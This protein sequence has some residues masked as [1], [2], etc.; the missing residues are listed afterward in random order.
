MNTQGQQKSVGMCA[1]PAPDH[2]AQVK[3]EDQLHSSFHMEKPAGDSQQADLLQVMQDVTGRVIANSALHLRKRAAELCLEEL[4]EYKRSKALNILTAPTERPGSDAPPSSS[5][6]ISAVPCGHVTDGSSALASK[7]GPLA[8]NHTATHKVAQCEAAAPK[9]H[10]N[11]TAQKL[12]QLASVQDADSASIHKQSSMQ[13]TA[14]RHRDMNGAELSA[15]ASAVGLLH[16]MQASTG[17]GSADTFMMNMP[18]VIPSRS[19]AEAAAVQVQPH[20]EKQ[21][22]LSSPNQRG[23]MTSWPQ[24]QSKPLLGPESWGSVTST[25][26]ASYD[27]GKIGCAHSFPFSKQPCAVIW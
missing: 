22:W 4:K 12:S 13:A 26:A 19:H 16:G 1:A 23:C 14:A 17:T 20:T 6:L 7:H 25:R 5:Y 18:H 10:Q 11:S 9:L 27:Q 15:A 24:G 3:V 8:S 2:S 21:Q